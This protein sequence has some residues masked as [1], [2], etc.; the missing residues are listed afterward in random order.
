MGNKAVVNGPIWK[1]DFKP[2]PTCTHTHT[3][4]D[5]CA[6]TCTHGHCPCV[7]LIKLWHFPAVHL[8]LSSSLL[9]STHLLLCSYSALSWWGSLFVL[10]LPASWV[11][12]WGLG[13]CPSLS[14]PRT[15][16][17]GDNDLACL[18][19]THKQLQHACGRTKTH[20]HRHMHTHSGSSSEFHGRKLCGP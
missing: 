5:M 7:G 14:S 12:D 8:P 11:A 16:G 2:T 13:V 19:H 15:R 3:R 10:S 6:D 9:L 1:Y 18:T 4:T 17:E 20:K